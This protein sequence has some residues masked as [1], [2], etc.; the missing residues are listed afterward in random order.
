MWSQLVSLGRYQQLKLLGLF[1]LGE[2]EER[3][4]I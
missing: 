3:P 2:I 1:S 4:D